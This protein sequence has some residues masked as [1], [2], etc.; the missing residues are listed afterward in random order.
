MYMLMR[1]LTLVLL[2]L[3]GACSSQ[4]QADLVNIQELKKIPVAPSPNA[5]AL[6]KF[7]EIPVGLSTGIPSISIPFYQYSDPANHIS[8]NVGLGY[9]ASGHKLE[10]MASN[11]GLGWAFN[12]GGVISRTMRGK[13]DESTYGYIKTQHLPYFFTDA[14]DVGIQPVTALSLNNGIWQ[15]N[16]SSFYTVQAIAENRLDGECD[17]FNLSIPGHAGKFFFRKDGTIQLLTQENLT[18]SYTQPTSSAYITEFVVHD[19]NGINYYLNKAEY[20][21]ATNS[22]GG[23]PLS[24]PPNYVSSWYLTKIA[25]PNGDEI[26]YHYSYI[27]GTTND[28][29]LQ[30]E[31][32]F[33]VSNR[34]KYGAMNNQTPPTLTLDQVWPTYSYNTMYLLSPRLDSIVF[35]DQTRVLLAYDFSRLDYAGDNALTKVKI[36]NGGSGKEFQLSYDYFVS[37]ACNPMSGCTPGLAYSVNDYYKRLKLLSVQESDSVNSLPPYHFEYNPTP[38]PNRNVLAHDWWGYYNGVNTTGLP[39]SPIPYIQNAGIALAEGRNASEP[40]TK[41][42]ILEKIFYPT[43]GNTRFYYEL[44]DGY[45]ETEYGSIGGLRVKK[46]E[47]FDPTTNAFQA[48]TYSYKKS[49]N[50]SS[51][52][53]FTVPGFNYNFNTYRAYIE[54]NEAWVSWEDSHYINLT[55]SPAHSLTAFNGSPVVYTRVVVDKSISGVPNGYSVHE[56]RAATKS[57]YADDNYPY[58]PVLDAEWSQG[59]PTKETVFNGANEIVK[60]VENEYDDFSAS[61]QP[62]LD[63]NSRNLVAG[64]YLSDN[65]PTGPSRIYAARAYAISY[66]RCPLKKKT[67][68]IYGPS[69]SVMTN[70]TEYTYDASTYL[71]TKVKTTNSKGNTE[72]TRMYYTAFNASSGLP[73]NAEVIAAENWEQQGSTMYL[74]KAVAKEYIGYR[75][76]KLIG[77]ELVQPINESTVGLFNPASL[78]RH[79]SF[80]DQAEISYD[81]RWR[82][83]EMKSP[84]NSY[85][86]FIWGNGSQYPLAAFSNAG[87]AQVAY[88]SFESSPYGNWTLASGASFGNGGITGKKYL[89]GSVSATVPS[90]T[91]TVS[92]WA[93]GTITVNSQSV[94]H[95]K[96]LG[97]WKYYEWTVT[98]GTVTVAGT[99][100]DEVRLYP[101]GAQVTTTTI[102]PLLGV[103]SQCD[104]ASRITYYV[105]DGFGRLFL[106]RDEKGNILKKFCYNYQGQIEDCSGV[107]TTPVW[108]ANGETRCKLCPGSTVYYSNLRERREKD[109]NPN[110][111]TYNTYRWVEE[112][113]SSACAA[114]PGWET[115][116]ATCLTTQVGY[117]QLV[118]QDKNPCSLTYNTTRTITV[119]NPTGCP[120]PCDCQSYGEA[121]K[122]VGSSGCEQGVKVYTDSYQDENGMWHCTYH[123]EWSDA[124]WSTNY[125]E[126]TGTACVVF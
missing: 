9:H 106:V 121:Y 75:P 111:P 52:T 126:V 125:V 114:E 120:D 16:A 66:G 97:N 64:T 27:A 11:V 86:A 34:A 24:M 89:D 91:Y 46:T 73:G 50:S 43:G 28:G 80:R 22:L 5:S 62:L 109:N 23:D 61:P 36:R 47:N 78:K 65:T 100:I 17:I 25:L 38:L 83:S 107:T 95:L 12:A 32:G 117:Q 82:V 2:L 45:Y 26:N 6:G 108:V 71:P 93:D 112:G 90:G 105:Y 77:T 122:C 48:T 69:A 72:E 67:E 115:Q 18:I 74:K 110:S 10:D 79:A 102:E 3:A 87:I 20:T 76:S 7:G 37:P 40:A 98:G 4:G 57:I 99:A 119:Y 15:Q 88:T 31:A 44:N 49:N 85:A 56:F 1:R 68:K 58:V 33:A 54:N 124:S 123:Y 118:Q 55:S 84:G 51:G 96:Q 30:Y 59:L 116:T 53:L 92:A 63:S 19:E 101:Q 42:W 8:V 14:Y 103:T 113:T 29:R 21:E 81:A 41:A 39:A 94:T 70:V 13:P 35:P 104:A 60:S